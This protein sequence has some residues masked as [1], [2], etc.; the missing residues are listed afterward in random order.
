MTTEIPWW[1]PAMTGREAELIAAVLESNY[2]N[3][4]EVTERFEREVAASCGARYAVAVTSGTAAIFLALVALGVGPGDEVIV[5]DLTFIATANAVTLAGATVVLADIDPATLTL[6][7]A[8]M[9]RAIGPRTRAVVPVHV[10]GRAA[11]MAAIC[12]IAS[13]AGIVV[14]EDAA[15]AFVSRH[16]GR[17]LGTIG[18]AGCLSFSP[19]KTVTTG[20]GGAVL[21][22]DPAVHGR[23]RELKDQ[24]R[25]VRG[26]GGDDL[27]PRV[28]F[29]FKL[30]NLQAAVGLAQ[31]SVLEERLE[32]QRR[33]Y[34]CY[35]GRLGGLD[36]I[37]LPGFR[38]DAGESPLW[39]DALVPGRRDQ[40]DAHLA[41]KRMGCRRF[42]HPLHAQA[43]YQRDAGRFP[44][45]TRASSD[46]LW[47]PSAFSLTD[48]EVG[49]VC[50][51]VA[52]FLDTA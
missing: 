36:G 10:S 3:E 12:E 23:L 11:D 17:A 37:R 22:D 45:A 35:A 4:G 15:E 29:N 24:G 43:P 26:T 20:Q 5:P 49:R 1:R 47:L 40:L 25:P 46:A 39:T 50:A 14:V 51:E 18:D 21:T 30:T 16:E 52:A 7:P 42:W 34:S 33:I 44:A 13:A 28:G 9:R 48:D 38:I 8:S 41:A 32:R 6:D 19:N 27:H 31:L 2:V